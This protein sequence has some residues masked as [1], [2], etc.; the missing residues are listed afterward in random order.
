M[1]AQAGHHTALTCCLSW[2]GSPEA[3][4]AMLR[5]SARRGAKEARRA[6]ERTAEVANMLSLRDQN[7]TRVADAGV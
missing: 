1:Q 6:G 5:R 3:R 2:A 4:T 7:H